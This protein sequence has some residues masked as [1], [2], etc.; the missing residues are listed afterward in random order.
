MGGWGRGV[1]GKSNYKD[2]NQKVSQ[3]SGYI[4]WKHILNSFLFKDDVR[5]DW[6]RKVVYNQPCARR[7]ITSNFRRII[8]NKVMS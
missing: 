1:E 4:D 3:L 6:H 5:K 7:G 8:R 2:C